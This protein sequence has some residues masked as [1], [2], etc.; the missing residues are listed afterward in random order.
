MTG[1]EPSYRAAWRGLGEALLR[2]GKHPEALRAAERLVADASLRCEGLLIKGQAAAAE[3]RHEAALE[4]YRRAVAEFP[5][6]APARQ[7]LCRPIRR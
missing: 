7:A 2:Q 3:G 5:A 4:S 6:D 1:E